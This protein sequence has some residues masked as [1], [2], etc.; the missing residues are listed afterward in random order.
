MFGRL[1]VDGSVDDG[2]LAAMVEVQVREDHAADIGRGEAD[3]R[4]SVGERGGFGS[5]PLVD[6]AVPDADPGVDEDD[7]VTMAHDPRAHRE[8]LE[9]GVLGIAMS[10]RRSRSPTRAARPSSREKKPQADS[11]SPVLDT[12]PLGSVVDTARRQRSCDTGQPVTLHA[13][14]RTVVAV[15]HELAQRRVAEARVGR[16]ATVKA[17][18]SPHIVP[19]CFVLDDA[20]DV[21]TAVDDVKPKSTTALHRLDNVRAH[22]HVALLVD[23]YSDDWSALWW[24]R[25]DGSAR[26]APARSREHVAARQLLAA[27]YEQYRLQPP[28]G[29][30]IVIEVDTWRTWP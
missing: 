12:A 20:S 30:V 29:P 10:G 15:E 26:V 22:P 13:F 27:K 2:V 19:C 4:Q 1:D 14:S 7:T 5:V 23:H 8:R 18:G 3:G 28:P 6:H 21:Y 17:D 11:T 25:L 16:L 9:G 24:I